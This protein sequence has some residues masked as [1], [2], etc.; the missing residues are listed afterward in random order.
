M[1]EQHDLAKDFETPGSPLEIAFML[2]HLSLCR[3]APLIVQGDDPSRLMGKC[4]RESFAWDRDMRTDSQDLS[5]LV[6]LKYEDLQKLQAVGAAAQAEQAKLILRNDLG[7]AWSHIKSLKNGRL[8][9]VMDNGQSETG[10][11]HVHG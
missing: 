4:D 1:V 9:I 11:V 10:A 3:N 8:D 5:L 7:K 6:D 2:V